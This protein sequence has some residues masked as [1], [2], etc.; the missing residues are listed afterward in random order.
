MGSDGQTIS[1]WSLLQDWTIRMKKLHCITGHSH[2]FLLFVL[3]TYK[4]FLWQFGIFWWGSQN[5]F[6]GLPDKHSTLFGDELSFHSCP[7]ISDARETPWIRTPFAY[8]IPS[9]AS[10]LL[11]L[12]F[13]L[14]PAEFIVGLIFNAVCGLQNHLCIVLFCGTCH[15]H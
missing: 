3:F 15:T 4:S 7:W 1:V 12:P 9:K 14:L 13:S 6:V 8:H 5:S 10:I 11:S 2:S